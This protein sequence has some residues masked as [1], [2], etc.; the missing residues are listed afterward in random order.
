MTSIPFHGRGT[1]TGYPADHIAKLELL[2]EL[3]TEKSTF[4]LQSEFY[5][6]RH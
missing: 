4:D 3:L 2:T 5:V 6:G 1:L